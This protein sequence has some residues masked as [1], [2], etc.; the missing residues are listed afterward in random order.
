[1]EY[2][3]H[4][5]GQR[6]DIKISGSVDHLGA[7]KLKEGFEKLDLSQTREVVIDMKG[8]TYIGSAGVGKLLLLYKNMPDRNGRISIVNLSEDIYY[9]LSDMELETIFSLTRA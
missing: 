5:Q 6:I 4:Q 7:E 1:M 9:L 2:E 8:A 3:I